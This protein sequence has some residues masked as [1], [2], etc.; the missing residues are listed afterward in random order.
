MFRCSV[1]FWPLWTYRL[2]FKYFL[3]GAIFGKKRYFISNM[4]FWFSVQIVFYTYITNKQSNKR[5]LIKCA[6]PYTDI[7]LCFYRF[8]DHH[9]G[10]SQEYWKIQQLPKLCKQNHLNVT[11]NIWSGPYNFYSL[12]QH[13]VLLKQFG[14]LLYFTNILV[15]HR[16]DGH[17]TDRIIVLTIN[18]EWYSIFCQCEFVGL[19]RKRQI[20]KCAGVEYIQIICSENRFIPKII[21]QY[22]NLRGPYIQ[23]SAV[24]VG[25]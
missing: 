21:Q 12:Q 8:C 11:V 22:I 16:G 9:R 3:N 4:F 15:R 2:S 23:V 24:S 13:V 6:L 17:K 14:L 20:R 1:I 18:T 10:T 5:P 25:V 19:L 7:H